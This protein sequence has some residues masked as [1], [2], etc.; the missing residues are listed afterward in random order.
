MELNEKDGNNLKSKCNCKDEEVITITWKSHHEDI[1]VEWA[2]KANCYKW[3]HNKSYHKYNHKRN[4]YTIPVIIL[5]TLT[6]TA[7]FALE[8]VPEE[9]QALCS[10]IIGSINII[11]GIITTIAQFLKLNELSEGYK[12]SALSWDKFYRNIKMELLKSANER[13]DVSYFL[14][15][16]KD[17]YDRLMET[18]PDIDNDI[19]IKFKRILTDAKDPAKR[20]I[21]MQ[22]YDELNK[23]ELFDE[24]R[25][26]KDQVNT[27]DIENDEIERE[28]KKLDELIK[29]RDEQMKRRA[30][31][32]NFVDIFQSKYNR[33]PTDD[34]V[35]E[36]DV[37]S[38]GKIFGKN[39]INGSTKRS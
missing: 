9:S 19:L 38:L 39:E 28:K 23:P 12:I 8:R 6:G 10:I 37:E 17:E 20:K 33:K 36:H 22:V 30:T 21:K 27:V 32:K 4:V 15:L 3:L 26:I 1:L 2:D 34:E 16:C 14:K 18:S 7:N 24:I 5:S 13:T 29:N 11:A 35:N 31:L 25:S